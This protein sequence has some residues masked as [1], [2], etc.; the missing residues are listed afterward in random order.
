MLAGMVEYNH[1]EERFARIEKMVETLQRESRALRIV[2]ARLAAVVAVVTHSPSVRA[3]VTRNS[4]LV[5][6]RETWS[7]RGARPASTA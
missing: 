6:S 4:K 7:R 5:T 3:D 2:T 1:D